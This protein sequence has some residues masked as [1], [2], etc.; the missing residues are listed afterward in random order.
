MGAGDYC[1]R[2]FSIQ[3]FGGHDQLHSGY[4]RYRGYN[5][6][7]GFCVLSVLLN[8][9]LKEKEVDC[10]NGGPEKLTGQCSDLHMG[11]LV[12]AVRLMGLY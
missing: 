1:L 11:V 12:R 7:R 9:M 2:I 10:G 3:S 6:M 4:R 5:K 8:R